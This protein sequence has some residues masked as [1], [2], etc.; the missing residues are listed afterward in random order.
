[1]KRE[2]IRSCCY[3]K[4]EIPG[5][6]TSLQKGQRAIFL[7]ENTG[8]CKILGFKRRRKQI[9]LFVACSCKSSDAIP[10]KNQAWRM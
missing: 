7:E 4:H 3:E 2:K 8:F 6:I 9:V 5:A 10:G 1:L